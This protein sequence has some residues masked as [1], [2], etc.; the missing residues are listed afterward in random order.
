MPISSSEIF[1]AE[2]S[3]HSLALFDAV[4]VEKL[5]KSLFEK[6]GKPFLKCLVRGRDIQAKPEEIVRQLWIH[7]LVRRYNYPLARLT[8]E[9]AALNYLNSATGDEE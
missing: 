2:D 3:K 8:T 6:N 4:E 9:A 1:H 5:E 7:R